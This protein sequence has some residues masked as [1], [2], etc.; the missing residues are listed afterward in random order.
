MVDVEALKQKFA[1]Y[2]G[3]LAELKAI[4]EDGDHY[5]LN[6]WASATINTDGTLSWIENG[7]LQSN[8]LKDIDELLTEVHANLK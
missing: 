4:E 5:G 2:P 6:A 8:S 3:I 1:G 7:M